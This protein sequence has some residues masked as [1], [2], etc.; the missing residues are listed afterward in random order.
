MI[1]ENKG[2]DVFPL[3]ILC[4]N[5]VTLISPTNYYALAFVL[6][7]HTTDLIMDPVTVVSIATC[8]KRVSLASYCR[9]M[10][11]NYKWL[12]RYSCP[13]RIWGQNERNS[14]A[15]VLINVLLA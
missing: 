6:Q 7:A 3:W 1:C 13:G 10:K 5:L 8:N 4:G 15:D 2:N 14:L 9:V 11:R 12:E